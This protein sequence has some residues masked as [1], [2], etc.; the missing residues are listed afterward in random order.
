MLDTAF[1]VRDEFGPGPEI[2]GY[3]YMPSLFELVAPGFVP[4][5]YANG[6][7][8]MKEMAHYLK[9]AA[10]ARQVIGSG[11]RD[12]QPQARRSVAVRFNWTG[13]PSKELR[14]PFDQFYVIEAEN[15]VGNT[16]HVEQ[17]LDLMNVVAEALALEFDPSPFGTEKA[18]VLSNVW[19]FLK[20]T[21]IE[22]Y[23]AFRG[24]EEKLV[25]AIAFP[26]RYSSLATASLVFD[27]PRLRNAAAF[28]LGTRLCAF[29]KGDYS[30][31]GHTQLRK[32]AEDL[33]KPAS[34]LADLL[35]QPS[36][37]SVLDELDQ[38]LTSAF[39]PTRKRI[40]GLTASDDFQTQRALITRL[41][42][43][44]LGV[45][46]LA[47][48]AVNDEL[49]RLTRT[50]VNEDGQEQTG[51]LVKHD[52]PRLDGEHRRLMRRNR[53]TLFKS[54][55]AAI[56]KAMLDKLVRPETYG[57]PAAREF[58][59]E[60]TS[61]LNEVR[62]REQGRATGQ[63]T[64]PA[65]DA[66]DAPKVE[67][68][69]NVDDVMRKHEDALA[70]PSWLVPY[71]KI[72]VNHY[73]AELR[74]LLGSHLRRVSADLT[75]YVDQVHATVFEYFGDLFERSAKDVVGEDRGFVHFYERIANAVGKAQT[76][77]KD[78]VSGEVVVQEEGT[79]LHL[80]LVRF[81]DAVDELAGKQDAY[82]KAFTKPRPE[83]RNEYVEGEIEWMGEVLGFFRD[84]E[85]ELEDDSRDVDVLAHLSDEFL[86]DCRLL[87]SGGEDDPDA[88]RAAM[89]ALVERAMKPTGDPWREVVRSLEQF[90]F[91]RLRGFVR[92]QDAVGVLRDQSTR[93]WKESLRQMTRQCLPWSG[94]P[95]AKGRAF[96]AEGPNN[97]RTTVLLGVPENAGGQTRREIE[98]VVREELRAHDIQ[99]P[100]APFSFPVEGG[101]LTLYVERSALPT[102]YFGKFATYKEHYA[103]QMA[104]SETTRCSRHTDRRW[105]RFPDLL[106]PET[107]REWTDYR[108]AMQ[109]LIE[110]LALGAVKYNRDEGFYVE[111]YVDFMKRLLPLQPSFD[112]S[113][114][115]L[116]QGGDAHD[117]L[118]E[119][120]DGRLEKLETL[121]HWTDYAAILR[122]YQTRIFPVPQTLAQEN[123]PN[124]RAEAV[125]HL[126]TEVAG[127]LYRFGGGE[128]TY[129]Q[130]TG[131]GSPFWKE[132]FG[133]ARSDEPGSLD[134]ADLSGCSVELEYQDYDMPRDARL[135]Q[136]VL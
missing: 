86:A 54:K 66:L 84:K 116:A 46:S 129:G 1:T 51:L 85:E 90:S 65:L 36:G 17:P 102:Y 114:E 76:L 106:M 117:R 27:R 11:E 3:S 125:S 124:V 110:G 109:D 12:A 92:D 26:R 127:Q 63:D 10:E 134:A 131:P 41:P 112:A 67:P 44:V 5:T 93:D 91:D 70:I 81:S 48:K 95:T 28:W 23:H 34:L 136:L 45:K 61:Y 122:R 9:P 38:R 132:Y 50:F 8:A 55:V 94:R 103:S 77:V 79:G 56:E 30:A 47:E 107:A 16:V 118:R 22:R 115:R 19:Q 49:A 31:R 14:D 52:D 25:H 35:R 57:L 99:A 18:S 4:K 53:K 126:L 130:D 100:Q 101:S 24:D 119:A 21:R 120:V 104:E 83:G 133:D 64:R 7:G 60:V 68:D 113:V 75:R 32:Q 39:L 40:A 62:E 78:K 59:E 82:H 69:V 6:Y 88:R 111:A 135:L 37:Q 87:P 43:F 15:S 98:E 74:G 123:L 128:E 58:L 29:W 71:R 89:Q 72:A 13:S 105:H 20:E 42:S 121:E 73:E 96:I 2:V 97:N 80:Q 33:L 108:D